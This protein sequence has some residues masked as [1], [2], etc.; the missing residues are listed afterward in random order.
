MSDTGHKSTSL[1]VPAISGSFDAESAGRHQTARADELK[2]Q[3]RKIESLLPYGRNARTHSA[4]QIRKLRDSIR[5]FG[6]LNPVLI[7]AMGTIIAGHGRVRAAKLL[8]MADV[9]T[10]CVEGLTP[11][12]IRAYVI[13]DNRLAEDAGWDSEILKIELQH[14]ISLPDFDVT[15]IGFEVPEMDLIIGGQPIAEDPEDQIP[16]VTSHVVTQLGDLWCLGDHRVYC[17]NAR[18][19][20]SYDHLMGTRQ[21]SVAFTDPPYN[22]PINGHASGNGQIHHAEF[23]MASGEMSESEFTSF[24]TESLRNLAK[25]SADGCVHFVA[26]DWGHMRELLAAGDAVY[27]SLLNVCVWAKD[28]G[29][30]GS[31][32]RSQHELIFVFK[33]GKAS[34][35]NNIQLGK[36]GRNRTNVWHYP[37]ANTL[38]RS[39]TDGNVLQMH[40][41]TK[42]ISMIADA[43]LDCSARGEIV[44]DPFLGSGST[45]LAAERVGRICYGMEL[46]GR[47][48]DLAVRRW[49]QITGERVHHAETGR[50]FDEISDEEVSRD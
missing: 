14:L 39:G 5:T 43:L 2:V 45:L 13:A 49:Q 1:N 33:V 38:S 32:Y 48:V 28:N 6:F 31:F 17:G 44:L 35:R 26:M 25:Y 7:S 4:S 27:D 30:L 9:P 40:P 42:P 15:V 29:G 3:Y 11:D 8:G 36:F 12:Q 34:H 47:Y 41:T 46:E 50:L 16:E 24:L 23:A 37:G 10:I 18:E 20:S 19:G 22:V 21:C